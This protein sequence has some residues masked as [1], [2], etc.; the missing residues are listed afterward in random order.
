MT[1]GP[2]VTVTGGPAVTPA[3]PRP[4]RPTG[5]LLAL[6]A[7]VVVAALV[8]AELLSPAAPPREPVRAEMALE[9]RAIQLSR[10]GVLVLPVDVVNAGPAVQVVDRVVAAT[11]VGQASLTTG[12]TRIDAGGTGRV[13]ALI[14]P[15]CAALPAEALTA[16]L[17]VRLRTADR[18]ERTLTLDLGREPAVAQYVRSACGS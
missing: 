7:A 18:A 2:P 11:P 5:P 14:Q 10:S 4:S 1:D 15:D 3:P 12:R 16:R 9:P 6:G 8:V 17:T 13:V